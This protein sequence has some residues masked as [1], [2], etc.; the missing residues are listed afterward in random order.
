MEQ[1]LGTQRVFFALWPDETTRAGLGAAARRMHRVLHGRRTRDESIHLTLAFIGEV[2]TEDLDRL[3]AVPPAVAAGAFTL[4]L[5]HWDCWPRNRI[6]WTGPASVPLQLERLA[7]NLEGWLRDI[8]FDLDK[9]KFAPHV[10][11]VRDA[12][13][14]AMP[15]VLQPVHWRVED[16]V[17]VRSQRLPRGSQYEVVARWPLETQPA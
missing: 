15:G 11:L 16:F 4:T 10:T 7:A 2:D 6:G 8:G 9:R 3:H 1:A 13:Y 17:L 14:A 12:Q 5:D